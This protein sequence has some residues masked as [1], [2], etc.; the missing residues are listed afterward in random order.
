MTDDNPTV[1]QTTEKPVLELIQFPGTI[2]LID[3]DAKAD[4]LSERLRDVT[5]LGFDTETRPSFRKGEVY[6]TAILQ[7]A[8]DDD[9]YVIQL[10]KLSRFDVFQR[11]FEE[12]ATLKVGVAIRD[13]LKKL[14]QSFPFLPENFVELQDLAKSKGLKNFGLQG[15]TEEVLQ[16]R[17]SKKAKITNWEARTLTREQIMY[18]ATDAWVGL[19]LFRKIRAL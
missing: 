19:E 7:L 17:L 6:K 18:A 16:A 5:E 1:P 15:M 11:I 4:L 8:T 14:K 2:H 13:D 12:K 9:A 3:N 10:Q